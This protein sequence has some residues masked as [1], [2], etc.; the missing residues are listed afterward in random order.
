MKY[1]SFDPTHTVASCKAIPQGV[2]QR[3]AKLTS[4][5]DKVQDAPI[6]WV[7]L[8]HAAALTVAG[9]KPKVWPTM[10]SL[11]K[12]QKMRDSDGK[13]L[14]EKSNFDKRRVRFVVAYSKFWG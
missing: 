6:N 3:L 14:S 9:L 13:S 1:V 12:E 2:F 5:T 10:R 4:E 8:E 11:W 7:Y